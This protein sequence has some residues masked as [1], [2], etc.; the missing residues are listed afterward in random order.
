MNAWRMELKALLEAAGAC[1]PPALRRSRR[2]DTLYATDLPGLV[3]PEAAVRFLKR[4]AESGWQGQSAAGWLHLSRRAEH[5]PEG[6]FAGPS[7]NEAACCLS[8]LERHGAGHRK[9]G[10]LLRAEAGG[11]ETLLAF[12]LIKAGEEGPEAYEKACARLHGDWAE[13]L[14]RKQALPAPDPAWFGKI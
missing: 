14:R 8:L 10:S 9:D 6:R 12:L 2:E 7:G 5:P 13:R 11:E 3:S 4:A 1:R